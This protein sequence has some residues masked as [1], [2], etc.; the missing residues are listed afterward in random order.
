MRDREPLRVNCGIHGIGKLL[1]KIYVSNSE[2]KSGYPV[3][4]DCANGA[5]SF[6]TIPFK[7]AI[8]G[9]DSANRKPITYGHS[10]PVGLLRLLLIRF[11]SDIPAEV[12][13]FSLLR[14][15]RPSR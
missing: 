1:L 2:H 9:S 13:W 7:L 5:V 15:P 3:S 6:H 4:P 11:Q 10:D 8:H 14:V 12:L